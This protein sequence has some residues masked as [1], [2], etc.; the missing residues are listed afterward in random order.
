MPDRARASLRSNRLKLEEVDAAD[1]LHRVEEAQDDLR[2]IY[3]SCTSLDH[4]GKPIA[5]VG[6][7][8][9]WFEALPLEDQ[10]VLEHED[11]DVPACSF[12]DKAACGGLLASVTNLQVA[13]QVVCMDLASVRL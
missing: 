1:S 5:L 7:L 6:Y 12:A 13:R 4:A 9:E 8:L 2:W 11:S 10:D 3:T